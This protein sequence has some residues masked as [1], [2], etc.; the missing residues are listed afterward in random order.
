[1]KLI[2]DAWR[3]YEIQ[4]VP[5]DAPEVQRTESRRAFYAGAIAMF[6]GINN[7]LSPGQEEPTA[8]DLKKMDAVDA[9]IKQWMA[10][11]AAGKV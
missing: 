9:E 10:D 5:L 4:I 6:G 1:V 7:M 2:A 3:D 8:E 11:L